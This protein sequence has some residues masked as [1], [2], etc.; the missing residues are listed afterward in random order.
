MNLI[1]NQLMMIVD[2]ATRK[3]TTKNNYKPTLFFKI[4][5]KK[6]RET[7]KLQ[8]MSVFFQSTD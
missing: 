5:M 7:T 6:Y 1:I 8:P 3:G 2:N 4:I